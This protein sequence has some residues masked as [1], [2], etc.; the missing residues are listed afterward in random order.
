MAENFTN[1]TSIRANTTYTGE[2]L[3][4]ENRMETDN[5]ISMLVASKGA[6]KNMFSIDLK[7]KE[8]FLGLENYQLSDVVVYPN[9]SVLGVFNLKTTQSWSIYNILGAKIKEGKGA[10]IDLTDKAKGVYLLRIGKNLNTY[11]L[12]KN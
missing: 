4:D 2:A 12:M 11:K 5:V 10:M 1:W 9:P 7:I 3:Y 6:S 8:T